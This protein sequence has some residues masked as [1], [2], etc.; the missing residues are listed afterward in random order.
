V[1]TR[2]RLAPATHPATSFGT[3]VVLGPAYWKNGQY[4]HNSTLT[5]IR[6]TIPS[7]DAEPTLQAKGVLPDFYIHY[8]LTVAQPTTEE[9]A[10]QI[11][12]YWKCQQACSV[13]QGHQAQHEGFKFVQLSSMYINDYYHD[14]DALHYVGEYGYLRTDLAN[15]E[16][17]LFARPEVMH[18]PWLEMAHFK[19]AGWQGATLSV[20]V[21][22]PS[23]YANACTPQG[24]VTPTADPNLD[25]V[26]AWINYDRAYSHWQVGDWGSLDYTT[27]ARSHPMAL[28][29]TPWDSLDAPDHLRQLVPTGDVLFGLSTGG[30]FRSEDDG[31]T[32]HP[33]T[34]RLDTGDIRA[35]DVDDGK[36]FVAC[37][38]GL[39]VSENLGESFTWSFH[40]TWDG[41]GSVDFRNGVGWMTVP[42]WGSAS[43]VFRRLPGGGWERKRGAPAWKVIADPLAPTDVA[44]LDAY[45][46]HYVT[47]DGGGTWQPCGEVKFATMWNGLPT[48]FGYN[49]FTQDR[50]RSWQPLGICLEAFGGSEAMAQ[51]EA[52]GLLFAVESHG[53]VYRGLPGQW[54]PCSSVG[55]G[56]VAVAVANSYLFAVT[57]EGKVF[58]TSINGM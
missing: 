51:D 19:Q 53:A 52:T 9:A 57:E 41:C 44:Y 47:L 5:E 13:D 4:V 21:T 10:C 31:T 32:W 30:L 11:H 25:P 22:I 3:S 14:A 6:A 49:S 34:I 58:R 45:P 24:W 27:T 46:S 37:D 42:N 38:N 50:G 7:D 20:S 17:S 36:L 1:R 16:G 43:G 33:V 26:G 54:K 18:D 12:Q 35:M 55:E 48:A 8:G 29:P 40:W 56:F 39:C 23:A 28:T 2:W 15:Q